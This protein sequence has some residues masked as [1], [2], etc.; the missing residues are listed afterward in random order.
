MS[1]AVSPYTLISKPM[2]HNYVTSL[3]PLRLTKFLGTGFQRVTVNQPIS[4]I[5]SS[6]SLSLEAL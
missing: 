5:L 6:Q 3:E 1:Q 4:E 2:I